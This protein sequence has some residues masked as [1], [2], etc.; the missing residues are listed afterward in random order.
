[1]FTRKQWLRA[2]GALSWSAALGFAGSAAAAVLEPYNV[3]VQYRPSVPVAAATITWKADAPRAYGYDVQRRVS[4]SSD[5]VR[6]RYASEPVRSFID[7]NLTPLVRYEYRVLAYRQGGPSTGYASAVTANALDFP[8]GVAYPN[9]ISPNNFS[10]AQ[11]DADVQAMYSAWKSV[12]LTTAGAGIGGVR[13]YKPAPDNQESVSEGIGY[14]MVISAY[15]ATASNTGKADFDGL[16][17]YYKAK[18]KPKTVN[19]ITSPSL[20]AWRIKADGTV[21]DNF[22]APDGDLDAAYALLVADKKWGSSGV[23][24]YKAE[25]VSVINNLMEWSV[26]N[27]NAGDRKFKR[28]FFLPKAPRQGA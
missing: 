28:P 13:V 14:G 9:G 5:W 20:M 19:G 10:Q 17:T 26:L 21:L 23:I 6:V 2:V 11:K 22:A 24:N 4:G 1:M 27:N 12:Y 16:L 8:Y 7:T 3:A 18:R 25:A 15:M